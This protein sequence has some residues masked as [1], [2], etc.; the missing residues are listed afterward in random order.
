MNEPCPQSPHTWHESW[1]IYTLVIAYI[2]WMQSTF[3]SHVALIRFMCEIRYIHIYCTHNAPVRHCGLNVLMVSF[4]DKCYTPYSYVWH[5][6]LMFLPWRM[7]SVGRLWTCLMHV[8]HA[9]VTCLVRKCDLPHSYSFE[10]VTWLI[11]MCNV[12]D[13]PY[14]YG[15]HDPS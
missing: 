10:Y 3:T 6:S 4:I 5:D 15:W 8:W 14:S 9:S 2:W 13:M 11:H 7:H 12:C 1:L